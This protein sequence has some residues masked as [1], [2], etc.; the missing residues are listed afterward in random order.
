MLCYDDTR[1][2]FQC[3]VSLL[4]IPAGFGNFGIRTEY[5]AFEAYLS[6]PFISVGAGGS[7][8]G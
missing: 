6:L 8:F 7:A 5:K 4:N 3:Y 2:T 1:A